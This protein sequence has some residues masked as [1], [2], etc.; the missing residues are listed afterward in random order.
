MKIEAS[1]QYRRE[2]RKIIDALL[3]SPEYIE[4]MYCLQNR[5]PLPAKYKDHPLSGDW[6]G[7]RDCHIKNDLLLIYRI[8]G[9]I[10]ELARLNT[11]AEIFG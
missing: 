11:H 2:I 10:L 7:F 1:K 8:S 9:D 5:L 4:V 3:V 6:Q